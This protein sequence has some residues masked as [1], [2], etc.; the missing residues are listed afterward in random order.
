MRHQSRF[1]HAYKLIFI[2]I[3]ITKMFENTV[4]TIEIMLLES[5]LSDPILDTFLNSN[6][7]GSIGKKRKAT[8]DLLFKSYGE[9]TTE[10]LDMLFERAYDY[11]REVDRLNLSPEFREELLNYASC[12]LPSS[13]IEGNIDGRLFLPRN[14]ISLL[15]EQVENTQD[16]DWPQRACLIGISA[17]ILSLQNFERELNFEQSFQSN[18]NSK[19]IGEIIYN[20][21]ELMRQVIDNPDALV[22]ALLPIVETREQYET[23]KYV[24]EK[25]MQT[26]I[27]TRISK[28]IDQ[29]RKNKVSYA[30][31]EG[32]RVYSR[33][34]VYSENPKKDLVEKLFPEIS[35]ENKRDF[36][37]KASELAEIDLLRDVLKR[38]IVENNIPPEFMKFVNEYLIDCFNKRSLIINLNGL[39]E[40]VESQRGLSKQANIQSEDNSFEPISDFRKIAL[41]VPFLPK[42]PSSVVG[43]FNNIDNIDIGSP[44]TIEL[45]TRTLEFLPNYQVEYPQSVVDA[46]GIL[47]QEY[48]QAFIPLIDANRENRTDYQYC[49]SNSNCDPTNFMVQID[50][51]GLSSDYLANAVN[52]DSYEIA[53]DLR[54]KIYE[55]ENSIADYVYLSA[56]G[57][58]IRPALDS[59]RERFGRPI[60]L[61]ATTNRKYGEMRVAEFGESKEGDVIEG[62]R[63]KSISGFDAFFGPDEFL[64]YIEENNGECEFLLYVRSSAPKE[65]LRNPSLRETQSLLQNAELRRIIKANTITFNIDNPDDPFGAAQRINDTKL[66]MPSMGMGYPIY[67][68][69]DLQ[70]REFEEFLATCSS[71]EKALLR[72]KPA[73]ESYGGY[74]QLRGKIDPQF[75]RELNSAMRMRGPYIMQPEIPYSRIIDN[76]GEEFIYID[77][78]YLGL[79]NGKVIYLGGERTLMPVSSQEARNGRVHANTDAILANIRIRK[80]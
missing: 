9:C 79:R 51:C 24:E 42:N 39:V 59:I 69:S 48:N 61:L 44:T 16:Y 54:R 33:W 26:Y 12:S 8:I 36:F 65:Q 2:N 31:G 77:R 74:G 70:T 76:N 47:Y 15:Q 38:D 32:N 57:V 6:L 80:P 14:P 10:L 3:I 19:A 20:R 68:V 41:K 27:K 53:Q 5:C 29:K 56:V 49:F 72:A 34:S 4:N 18:L 52:L 37:K 67:S 28:L 50:M 13:L 62:E 21:N 7:D 45:G 25:L 43:K 64:K 35:P 22:E 55:I 73:L 40:F 46:L 23:C 1:F 63:V 60:A 30:E 17:G 71:E 58:D 78:N 11:G 66:Y 75:N